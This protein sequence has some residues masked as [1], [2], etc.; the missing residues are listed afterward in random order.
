M[1]MEIDPMRVPARSMHRHPSIAL[2]LARPLA[3]LSCSCSALVSSV[4]RQALPCRKLGDDFEH[5]LLGKAWIC[6][7]EPGRWRYKV[8]ATRPGGVQ[9]GMSRFRN[10]EPSASCFAVCDW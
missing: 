4:S 9:G 5:Q 6:D 2:A 3:L 7:A 8:D 1:K 10:L